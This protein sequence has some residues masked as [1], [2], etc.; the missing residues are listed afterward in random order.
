[1][2]C[3]TGQVDIK[4][5]RFHETFKCTEY[6]LPDEFHMFGN[7]VIEGHEQRIS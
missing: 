3:E 2:N 5:E 7:T 6:S 1:M 4:C